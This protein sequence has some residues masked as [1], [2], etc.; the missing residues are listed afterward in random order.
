VSI[1]HAKITCFFNSRDKIEINFIKNSCVS[2]MLL[3]KWIYAT[4]INYVEG[5]LSNLI[6]RKTL[7]FSQLYVQ[8]SLRVAK[9]IYSDE[10]NKPFYDSLIYYYYF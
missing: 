4:F 7:S 3:K 2:Y 9:M 1:E 10:N 5:N 8:M 6:W